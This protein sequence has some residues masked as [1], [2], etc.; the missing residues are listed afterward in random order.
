MQE[1][2]FIGPNWLSQT[3]MIL[4]SNFGMPKAWQ[5]NVDSLVLGTSFALYYSYQYSAPNCF[6]LPR[7]IPRRNL[8]PALWICLACNFVAAYI[9]V[10]W[11]LV[12]LNY[13]QFQSLLLKFQM[14]QGS[15]GQTRAWRQSDFTDNFRV[16]DCW[17]CFVPNMQQT[18]TPSCNQPNRAH[19]LP[20][21]WKCNKEFYRYKEAQEVALQFL[22]W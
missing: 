5:W 19:W 2:V 6:S 14:K 12:S 15:E 21:S 20:H 8:L 9:L 22:L 11:Y 13:T 3:C 1:V 18:L 16:R 4:Y 10:N 17:C 7:M